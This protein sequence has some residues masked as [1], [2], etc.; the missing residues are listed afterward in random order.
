MQKV[1]EKVSGCF[2]QLGSANEFALIRS[3]LMTC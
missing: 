3:C 2:R 1:K